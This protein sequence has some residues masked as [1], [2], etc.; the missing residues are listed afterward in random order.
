MIQKLQGQPAS[1]PLLRA[2]VQDL[3]TVVMPW[4]ITTPGHYSDTTLPSLRQTLPPPAHWPTHLS[5]RQ[6]NLLSADSDLPPLVRVPPDQ[7]PLP[8]CELL[9]RTA[10]NGRS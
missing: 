7:Q 6:Y 1:R 3:Q 2:D 9:L 4:C 8:Q 10:F 5:S